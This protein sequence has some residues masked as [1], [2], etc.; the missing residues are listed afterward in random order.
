M[1]L[2]L[3]T[4]H[5]T[6]HDHDVSHNVSGKVRSFGAWAHI[7]PS[8]WLVNSEMTAEEINLSLKEVINEADLLFV[9]KVTKDYAA[10]IHPDAITWANEKI[11]E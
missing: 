4:Y 6:V 5:Q 9:T 10:C 7:M 1:S 3:V 8:A 11:E 2:Y